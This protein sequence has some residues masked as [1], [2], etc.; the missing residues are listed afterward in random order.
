MDFRK[1]QVNSKNIKDR[2]DF[3]LASAVAMLCF[4]VFYVL[5]L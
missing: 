2:R 5:H 1:V 4:E 3:V